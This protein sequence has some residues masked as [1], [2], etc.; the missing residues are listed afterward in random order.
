ML[1]SDLVFRAATVVGLVWLLQQLYRLVSIFY[2]HLAFQSDWKR[3][4]GAGGGAE[5]RWAVVTGCTDG[6]GKEYAL[7]LADK[8][9]AVLL[10]ARSADKL[11]AVAAEVAARPGGKAEILVMDF[12]AA[13]EADYR[14]YRTAI[15][16][17]KVRVL[18]NNVG[19][20]YPYPE[21]LHLQSE[22]VLDSLQSVNIESM[23][24]MT[25]ITIPFMLDSYRQDKGR[26]LILNVGSFSYLGAP[27]LG[28][29]AGSKGF[30]YSF[31]KSLATD[32]APL[33]IDVVHFHPLFIATK[34]AKVRNASLF[35]PSPEKFAASS[36]RCAADSSA[37]GAGG[38]LFHDLAY[39]ALDLVPSK[40]VQKQGLLMH[41]GL[42]A[43]AYKKF[44]LEDP[45][46]K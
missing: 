28:A 23:I 35:T 10:V 11:K 36:L 24:Q 4:W 12:S 21:Y 29:Y 44:N 14:R 19:V 13:E 41:K 1:L 33:G 20:S 37:N 16:G 26:S 25:R 9:Y 17:K 40:F 22:E 39:F 45:L 8:G 6:I 27:L 2:R 18:V 7:Q 42:R 32:Y 5:Q 30:V 34:L 43:R 3:R 15:T 31:S 46:K 38:Y